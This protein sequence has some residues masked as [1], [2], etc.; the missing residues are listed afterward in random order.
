[1]SRFAARGSLA[2]AVALFLVVT[3]SASAQTPGSTPA[4]TLL[5]PY[6]EV[7][8]G[9][10]EALTTLF[11]VNNAD[12]EPVVAHIVVWT[13]WG[14][15]TYSFD[16]AL[17]AN[18]VQTV[19]LRDLFTTG[20]VPVTD[21]SDIPGCA[22]SVVA[23]PLGA[24]ALAALRAS[25]SGKPDPGDGLCRGSDRAGEATFVGYVTV[26]AARTCAGEA[27]YFPGD[28]DYFYMDF[29]GVPLGQEPFA[30]DRNVLWG[31]LFYVSSEADSAQGV[32]LVQI[33]YDPGAAAGE[34]FYRLYA[35]D[36]GDGRAMLGHHYR[37]RYLDGGAFDG[38]T[39]LQ[40]WL[41]GHSPGEP[42]VCGTRELHVD[43]CWMAWIDLADEDGAFV[44]G[45]VKTSERLAFRLPVGGE[46]LPTPAA[47]GF[48]DLRYL[49]VVGCHVLPIG[50]FPAQAWVTPVM[51]AQ[52]RFSV[53]LPATRIPV[54]EDP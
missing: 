31:D 18:D 5:L 45:E 16:L 12:T 23:P 7:D 30:S 27:T 19:N 54:A 1:M 3:A 47:F 43:V 40:V 26:D 6:F 33:P 38:G 51:K 13:D 10:S 25:H 8:A 29:G 34:T 2:P 22:D 46:E 11:S 36:G 17:R 39:D 37:G 49:N 50:S 35:G 44:A 28:L 41:E 24:T 53:G 48:F 4:A 20:A 9:G 42:L 15:P 21:G 32:E 14:V 52:G